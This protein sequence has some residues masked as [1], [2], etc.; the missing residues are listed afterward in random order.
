MSSS[1]ESRFAVN[2][3][4]R[5]FFVRDLAGAGW[6][7]MEEALD[8]TRRMLMVV[9]EA[10]DTAWPGWK[11]SVAAR[12]GKRLA[13]EPLV[14]GGGE[15]CKRDQKV[16]MRV[17]GAIHEHGIDRHSGVMVAG[18]GAFLDAVGFAAAT[19]HRGVRLL[20]LPT[21]TLSQGDS[22]VGVKCGLNLF[23]KKNFLGAFAVPYAVV[24]DYGFLATQGE[25]GR[26]EGL[27]E[28]VKVAA[29]KDA[30]FFEW[31]EANVAELRDLRVDAVEEAVRRSAELHFQHITEGGDPFEAGSSRPLDFGHWSA[32]KLESMS[33]YR[34]SHARAV[35]IGLAVDT[36][37]S[38]AVG[39]LPQDDACRM[40]RLLH[41]LGLRLHHNM[42]ER[43]DSTGAREVLAGVE[44]FRE[45][46]G[47]RLT[48][49]MLEAIGRGRDVNELDGELVDRC[50]AALAT[51]AWMEECFTP[52]I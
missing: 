8:D 12:L 35:G 51:G 15:K 19:A 27:V 26:R 22:G 33:G 16:W 38:H 30:D 48:V 5:V 42:L 3:R 28:A 52:G 4:H 34:L 36:L 50:V 47:G 39:L 40:L 37:Y 44:E 24:N 11:E 45:H 32:H 14:L 13:G 18:G 7:V 10:V 31:L 21:T 1:L 17:V 46:L 29:I 49:L 6:P 43:R 9:E 23:G 25:R 20:R 41:R 2:F